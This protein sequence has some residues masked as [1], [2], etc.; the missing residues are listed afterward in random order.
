M[1]EQW[2][3]T[4]Q[5]LYEKGELVNFAIINSSDR[6][7]MG[8]IGLQIDQQHARAELGYWVGKRFWNDGSGTEAAAAVVGYGFG[9]LGLNRIFASHFRRNPASGRVMQKI[10]MTY[11]GCLRQHVQKWGMFEDLEGYGI[12]KSEYALQQNNRII[13]Q[14]G[15][16]RK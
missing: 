5:G 12:L 4:H 7:L 9:V 3:A 16:P 11:E 8:A 14:T 2:I 13:P 15:H 6:V 1:A 10:G